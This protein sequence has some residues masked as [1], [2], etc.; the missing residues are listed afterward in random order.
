MVRCQSPV[1][2]SDMAYGSPGQLFGYDNRTR[3]SRPT[4]C[5]VYDSVG[6]AILTDKRA[7]RI[8]RPNLQSFGAPPIAVRHPGFAT[9]DVNAG[10]LPSSVERSG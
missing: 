5:P 1:R 6:R 9:V 8:L 10:Y 3:A 4:S 7:S 2:T